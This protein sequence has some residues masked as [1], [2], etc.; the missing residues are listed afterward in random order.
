MIKMKD[1]LVSKAQ[2]NE[3]KRQI[4]RKVSNLV[5]A[6]LGLSILVVVSICIGMFYNLIMGMLKDQCV[7]GTNML[8]YELKIIQGQMIKQAFLTI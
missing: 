5:A 3:K 8:A 7:S 2:K 1:S 6:M 4:G